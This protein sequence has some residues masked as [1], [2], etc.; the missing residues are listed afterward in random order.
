MERNHSVRFST[1]RPVEHQVRANYPSDDAL[2]KLL[3]MPKAEPVEDKKFDR[4]DFFTAASLDMFNPR[5]GEK[6]NFGEAEANR[7]NWAG[8]TPL[9]YAIYL[10]HEATAT[11]LIKQGADVEA[12]N[13]KGQTPLILAAGCNSEKMVDLLL[14]H[15]ARIDAVDVDGRS[16][17]HY[18]SLYDQEAVVF[19]L[20]NHGSDPNLADRKSGT[21]PLLM[22]CEGGKTKIIHEM[23]MHGGDPKIRNLR[24]D[25][26][27]ELVQHTEH[28]EA[29]NL[30]KQHINI[31][32]ALRQEGLEKYIPNFQAQNTTWKK[33]LRMGNQEFDML[34]IDLLGP[35]KKLENIRKG[36][37]SRYN[38]K[39]P[40]QGGVVLQ[41]APVQPPPAPLRPVVETPG[42]VENDNMAKLR[43][44]QRQLIG[45]HQK[46]SDFLSAQR[47][48]S[49]SDLRSVINTVD[50]INSRISQLL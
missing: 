11:V 2:E 21:T 15:D 1:N 45:V 33:F 12:K 10:G 37:L 9:M 40:G 3:A 20:L 41:Q 22:A 5:T 24:N 31:Y 7:R 6:F 44:I 28:K 46:L 42:E 47:S 13:Q 39:D 38:L 23:L 43:I 36:Y 19:L 4:M 14:R 16:A 35:K 25:S 18:A 27:E 48:I 34:G 29:I 50:E 30:V 26:G 17:L 8:W 49:E 32:E